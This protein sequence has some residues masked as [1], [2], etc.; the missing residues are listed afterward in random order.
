SD[1]TEPD[2]TGYTPIHWAALTGNAEAVRQLASHGVNVNTTGLIGRTPL[3]MLCDLLDKGHCRIDKSK[4]V[5]TIEA[6]LEAGADTE[7]TNKHGQR[8]L[9]LACYNSQPH[10]ESITQRMMETLIKHGAKTDITDAR[11]N[12]LFHMAISS[13][14]GTQVDDIGRVRLLA[15]HG[16]SPNTQNNLGEAPIMRAIKNGNANICEYLI[17]NG[18]DLG[19][20]TASGQTIFHCA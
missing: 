2:A 4:G 5:D 10:P 13:Q 20:V 19:L 17:K 11:G 12:T 6:L 16:L 15:E 3:V 7:V 14:N 18:A 8:P 9:E 1:L